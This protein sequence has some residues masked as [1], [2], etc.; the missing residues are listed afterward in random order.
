MKNEKAIIVKLQP[1]VKGALERQ[2]ARNGRAMMREAEAI[3]SR[4]VMKGR[5]Q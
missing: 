5:R 1:S 3:I 2:A 4:D